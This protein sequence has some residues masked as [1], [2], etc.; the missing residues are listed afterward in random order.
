MKRIITLAALLGVVGLV[1]SNSVGAEPMAGRC[2]SVPPICAPGTRAMCICE[3]DISM[4]C[5]WI[6]ASS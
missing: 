1:L 4:N 3:S 2:I 6:C 5:K